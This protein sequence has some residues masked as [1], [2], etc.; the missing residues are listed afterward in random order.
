MMISNMGVPTDEG[1][2]L[3]SFSLGLEMHKLLVS[4]GIPI[5]GV[6]MLPESTHHLVV[7]GVKAAY[8]GIATQIGNLIYGSKLSPWFHMTIVVDEDTDIYSKD[9]VIHA[10]EAGVNLTVYPKKI[11]IMATDLN[12]FLF[13]NLSVGYR[14]GK[15]IDISEAARAK[16]RKQRRQERKAQKSTLPYP[17]Y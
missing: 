7:V 13:F 4:Q 9:A 6:Y 1:Q 12:S 14:F 17:V 15:I 3:R 11:P 16:S 5:T 2:L 10:L 8:T